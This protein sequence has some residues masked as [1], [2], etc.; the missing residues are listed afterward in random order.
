MILFNILKLEDYYEDFKPIILKVR[1]YSLIV[2]M[3]PVPSYIHMTVTN[4][5]AHWLFGHCT[6]L[7]SH[8]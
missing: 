2:K 1:K 6:Q 5:K 3:Q 4:A 7:N 8:F